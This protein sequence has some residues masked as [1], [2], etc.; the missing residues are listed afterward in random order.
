MTERTRYCTQ[1]PN[2]E[3]LFHPKRLCEKLCYLVDAQT[4][5]TAPSYLF[6]G[7]LLNAYLERCSNMSHRE[8]ASGRTMDSCKDYVSAYLGT[9]WDP[10]GGAEGY[11]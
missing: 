3:T 5:A 7:Y 10:P 11:V 9:H 6:F 2:Y 1:E 4:K 8:K